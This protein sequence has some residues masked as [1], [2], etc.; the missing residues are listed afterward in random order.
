LFLPGAS[1]PSASRQILAKSSRRSETARAVESTHRAGEALRR[2]CWGIF[3]AD[4]RTG[5]CWRNGL[6]GASPL[7]RYA[8][9]AEAARLG[10]AAPG[11][12]PCPAVR[13]CCA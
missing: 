3:L 2:P 11:S 12:I 8:R 1:I 5:I 6:P 9:N 10:R 7:R 4:Y 13:P